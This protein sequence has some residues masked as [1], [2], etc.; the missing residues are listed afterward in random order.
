MT[1]YADGFIFK[2]DSNSAHAIRKK[3]LRKNLAKKAE[4]IY[5]KIYEKHIDFSLRK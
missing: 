1:Q 2:K 4:K 5:E 3:A